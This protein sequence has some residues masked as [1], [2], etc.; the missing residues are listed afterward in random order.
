MGYYLPRRDN[1]LIYL[2]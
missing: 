1:I 2:V